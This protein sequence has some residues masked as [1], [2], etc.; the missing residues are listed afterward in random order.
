MAQIQMNPVQPKVTRR[1]SSMV[2]FGGTT[3]PLW[4][5]IM[6]GFPSAFVTQMWDMLMA[7]PFWRFERWHMD[8]LT[9]VFTGLGCALRDDLIGKPFVDN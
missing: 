2:G 3:C 9:T 8:T 5:T 7:S 6:G 1:V 4:I